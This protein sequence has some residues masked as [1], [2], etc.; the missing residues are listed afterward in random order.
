MSA[1]YGFDF[2]DRE[3]SL[4]V[5]TPAGGVTPHPVVTGAAYLPSG[6]LSSLALGNG[7]SETR[8]FDG[9]YVPTAITL[10]GFLE[11][12]RERVDRHLLEGQA[13]EPP[14]PRH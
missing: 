9:R 1:T 10:S 7:A 13:A 6:P 12:A 8:A 2:A 11:Q 5:T 4:E 3:A 14:R